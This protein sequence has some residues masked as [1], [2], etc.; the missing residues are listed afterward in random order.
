MTIT[1][2]FSLNRLLML[3]LAAA[4]IVAALSVL[5][6]A[7]AGNKGDEAKAQ[8]RNAAGTVVGEVK[9]EQERNGVDVRVKVR[10]LTPGFH[11]FHIHTTGSCVA[12]DFASAGSHYNPTGETHGHHA[13]DMPTLQVNPD[14]TGEARFTI[15][16]F[17]VGQLFDA[18]GSALIVHAAADNYANIPPRYAPNG[19]DATTLGTGDSGS[20]VACGVVQLDD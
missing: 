20:R 6:P 8:L 10:G 3:A 13:G 11:G 4:A 14:G 2:H 15:A 5:R 18:D 17:Q 19:P 12:A 16:S 1:R 9:F 7:A